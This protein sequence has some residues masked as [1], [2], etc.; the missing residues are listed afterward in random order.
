MGSVDSPTSAEA[1]QDVEAS[2]E[3]E[4]LRR[5]APRL[6][7]IKRRAAQD[8]SALGWEAAS[9]RRLARETGDGR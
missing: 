5:M 8:E 2:W 7:E 1:S 9:V 3:A 4:V 6:A